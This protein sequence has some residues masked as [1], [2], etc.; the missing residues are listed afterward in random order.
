M[1]PSASSSSKE[2]GTARLLG[3]ATSGILE[4]LGF[5]P[6]DTVAKR[7]M[8]NQTKA[9]GQHTFPERMAELN[10]VIFKDAASKGTFKKYLSLFPG[11]GFAAGYKIMQRIY[12][13]GGQPYVNEYLNNN[14]KKS[15]QSAFGDAHAKTIIH[16]T[17]GS[18]IGIGEIVLLPLDAL[19]IKMQTNAGSYSGQ[20]VVQIIRQEGWGLYRGATWTAARNAPGSFALFGGSAIVKEYLFKLEDYNKATFLQNFVASISGAM[21]SITISAPLDVIK[22]RIQAKTASQAQGGWTIVKEMAMKEGFGSF[23][24][25]LTPKIL[26]VGPKLIF[27]FTVAQQLIPYFDGLIKNC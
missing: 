15:F 1:S 11:L 26:V 14:H 22:T 12:K 17:A 21:A 16:A 27:S 24:K 20:S 3:A 8:N 13:F 4:L 25:G 9:V 18:M 19:K 10:K 5:H 2:S 6:I 23:F 7:L